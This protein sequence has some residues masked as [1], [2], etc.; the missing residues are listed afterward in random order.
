MAKYRGR[1]MEVFFGLS[2]ALFLLIVLPITAFLSPGYT[3]LERMISDLGYYRAKSLFSIGF[4]VAG[5]LLIPFYISLEK[6][7][8]NIKEVV[9]RFATGI[10]IVT[11]VCIALVGIIPDETYIDA[12]KIFHGIIAVVSFVGSSVYI[13][14]YS[15]L[16]YQ[17][18]ESKMYKGPRFKKYLAYYGFL[19]GILML[20]FILT[21][22]PLLEWILAMC[23]LT[24]IIIAAFQSIS[25]KFFN[26][27]GIYYKRSQFSEALTLFEGAIQ[28]LDNLGMNDEPIAKTI[29]K[30]IAF[31]KT[32]LGDNATQEE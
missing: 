11:N 21:Q 5:S 13:V 19:I 1:R 29:Q 25:F 24:W 3:P 14:L 6:E 8:I 22:I 28:V 12:F 4:V 10:A 32:K 31:I 16:M 20:V 2:G 17:G 23:M 15:I 9:R 18:P 27:P 7:L 26:I 30:N